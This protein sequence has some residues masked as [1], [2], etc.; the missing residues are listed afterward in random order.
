MCFVQQIPFNDAMYIV[1]QCFVCIL[2]SRR[3]LHDRFHIRWN[4]GCI[5]P[6]ICPGTS[7]AKSALF[8]TPAATKY[9]WPDIF[10]IS[11]HFIICKETLCISIGTSPVCFHLDSFLL[12]SAANADSLRWCSLAALRMPMLC[13]GLIQW[14]LSSTHCL[15]CNCFRSI[16]VTHILATPLLCSR[17]YLSIKRIVPCNGFIYWFRWIWLDV[18][19]IVLLA[20]PLQ[21]RFN[22]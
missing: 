7:Y 10:W 21:M 3:P 6:L 15:F 20:S 16:P 11:W 17:L 5:H 12:I 19:H 1:L 18:W 22:R 4:N 14:A 13:F 9:F 8:T 2:G